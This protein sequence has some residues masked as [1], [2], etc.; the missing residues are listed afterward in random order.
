MRKKFIASILTVLFFAN[1]GIILADVVVSNSGNVYVGT[2]KSM[3]DKALE[4]ETKDG[5]F[6]FQ[7]SEIKEIK[8]IKVGIDEVN[9]PNQASDNKVALTE[10]EVPSGLINPNEASSTQSVGVTHLDGSNP[11]EFHPQP[12]KSLVNQ[13]FDSID[14]FGHIT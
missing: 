14:K 4:I 6:Q 5:S 12:L 1:Q 3:S 8:E 7:K 11:W 13:Y 10:I 2:I 9:Q